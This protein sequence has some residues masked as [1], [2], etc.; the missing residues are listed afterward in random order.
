MNN[1]STKSSSPVS[2]D[3]L[4]GWWRHWSGQS[5]TSNS[6]SDPSPMS[7]ACLLWSDLCRAWLLVLWANK[8]IDFNGWW[9]IFL[10]AKI[11][12]SSENSSTGSHRRSR[13]WSHSVNPLEK[14]HNLLVESLDAWRKRSTR[15]RWQHARATDLIETRLAKRCI[16]HWPM[17]KPENKWSPGNSLSLVATSIE[18]VMQARDDLSLDATLL[19]PLCQWRSRRSETELKISGRL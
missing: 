10:F 7:I 5:S 9:R 19:F 12:Q 11:H 18:E 13:C 14:C 15:A 3:F 8:D 2:T 6:R 1:S 16:I 4:L 17:N